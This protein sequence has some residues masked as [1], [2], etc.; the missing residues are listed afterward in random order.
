MV[1]D[2]KKLIG[3]RVAEIRQAARMSQ[4]D[5]AKQISVAPETLSRLER[6]HILP[7][8]K[9]FDR[10]AQALGVTLGDI[11]TFPE[12]DTEQQQALSAL[13]SELA[14]CSLREIKLLH[15]VAR[16]ILSEL[17]GSDK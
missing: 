1:R 3:A 10:I 9:R 7:S 5:L 6:G 14:H 8:V 15:G 12:S 11:F 16:L 2:L 17:R 4:Q 13:T